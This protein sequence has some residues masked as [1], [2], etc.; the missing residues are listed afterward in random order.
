MTP[1]LRSALQQSI[2]ARVI[3]SIPVAG[4]D[5]SEAFDLTLSDGQRIFLKTH[6][7]APPGLFQAEALGLE[8]LRNAKSLR[9]PRVLATGESP[10]AFLALE[11]LASA[12]PQKPFDEVLGHGLAAMH[13]RTPEFEGFGFP[14]DN[15]IA[16]LPQNNIS[17]AT[18]VEFYVERR[19]RLQATAALRGHRMPAGWTNRFERLYGAL[20]GF[21]PEEPPSRLHGDLWGGNLLVGPEGEP[22][23]VDPAVYAGHREV[24]LAMMK[25]F[26]G[27]SSTVFDAYHEAF[28]LTDGFRERVLLYQLYPLLVHLNLFGGSY[29]A[30]VDRAL[31]ALPGG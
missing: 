20:P 4:G 12:A 15:F 23:L 16:V 6:P 22:C 13:Q 1:E 3:S 31:S 26:G 17:C 30:S 28:P 25:L 10:C 8:W 19:L 24:D 11:H 2:G 21:V 27:F 29:L 9:V 14:E 7:L 18:W 5:V